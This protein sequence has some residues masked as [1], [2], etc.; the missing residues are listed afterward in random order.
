MPIPK[1]GKRETQKEFI[2]RCAGSDAMAD[3]YPDTK[4]RAAICY[5]QWR[6]KDK[7]KKKD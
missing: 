1:P 3:E 5:S 7:D 4:Q 2:Q 6:D